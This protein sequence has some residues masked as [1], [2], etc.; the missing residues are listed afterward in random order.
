LKASGHTMESLNMREFWHRNMCCK[1]N[2][3]F[4]VA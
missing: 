4:A 3:V 2:L 1:S